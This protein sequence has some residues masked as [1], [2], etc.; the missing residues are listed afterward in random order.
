MSLTITI[1]GV[2]LDPSARPIPDATLEFETL[3]NSS[4]TQLKSYV[5]VT[6]AAD[7]TYSVDLVPNAYSVSEVINKRR[8]WLGNIRIFPDS[9]PGTVN[10]YLTAFRPDQ[11]QP[12]ILDE[13]EEIL[14]D[15]KRAAL[16]FNPR[17]QW[18]STADYEIDDLVEYAGSEFRATQ[19]VIGLEP[20][21][22]P[23][24]L[25][26]SA[27]VPGPANELS[28][29]TVKSIPYGQPAAVR[30]DGDSPLQTISFD[31]PEGK[32][33]ENATGSILTIQAGS[34][35]DSPKFLP[36][37]DGMV[38][39]GGAASRNVQNDEYDT[40]P[41]LLMMTG[42]GG[43]LDH[44]NVPFIGNNQFFA[45]GDQPPGM[46]SGGAIGGISVAIATD[47]RRQIGVDSDGNLRF[48]VSTGD[49][50]TDSDTPWQTAF[51]DSNPQ[52]NVFS[53]AQTIVQMSPST[54][55]PDGKNLGS[56]TYYGNFSN[57]TLNIDMSNISSLKR[58]QTSPRYTLRLILTSQKGGFIVKL[59]NISYLYNFHGIRAAPEPIYINS[60]GIKIIDIIVNAGILTPV[61]HL[62]YDSVQMPIVP[63]LNSPGDRGFFIMA[64]TSSASIAGVFVAGSKLTPAGVTGDGAVVFNGVGIIP[65]T[66]QLRGYIAASNTA[67]NTASEFVRVDGTPEMPLQTILA[68]ADQ[69]SLVRGCAYASADGTSINCEVYANKR[70][71]P[72]TANRS[73]SAYWGSVIYTNAVAGQYGDVKPYISS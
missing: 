26:V 14:E 32:A 11:V 2:Y 25:F 58:N 5:S 15:T 60:G 27:G 38:T 62:I 48:R 37:D 63:V 46:N 65:G 35:D 24:E 55:K 31:I 51:S 8:K 34:A 29:G 21:A 3:Y 10:E 17:G 1:S 45:S 20:P 54:Y 72:F 50:P 52:P 67:P 70:W 30:I 68:S 57:T 53:D 41:G 64:G 47:D 42:A 71:W 9:V 43:M 13:M 59:T 73:D 49:S 56:E 4:Q 6:T 28:I 44:G 23:W 39:I 61:L 18:I 16:G 36:D 19:P 66:W 40:T 22:A 7:A 12:G 69:Q 33:G